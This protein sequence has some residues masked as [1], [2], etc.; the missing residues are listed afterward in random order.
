MM[1]DETAAPIRK[2]GHHIQIS[3]ETAL[4]FGLIEP[5]DEDR[6][7]WAAAEA[8]HERWR[9]S[10]KGRRQRFRVWV[11]EHR[12]VVHLGDCPEGDYGD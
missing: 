8:E 5:T 11:R 4:D 9:R 7:R 12:P 3:R 1:S 6:A 2:I 10:F